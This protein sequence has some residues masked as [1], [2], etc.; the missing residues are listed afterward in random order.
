[1]VNRLSFL[2]K[3]H[4]GQGILCLLLFTLCAFCTGFGDHIVTLACFLWRDSASWCIL[5]MPL[6]CILPFCE[7][8]N[9]AQ[10]DIICYQNAWRLLFL[11]TLGS[12]T[13]LYTKRRIVVI[14]ARLQ[15]FEKEGSRSLL[16]PSFL[17]PKMNGQ[18]T[19]NTTMRTDKCCIKTQ[20]NQW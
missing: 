13:H 20:E 2:E 4:P 16:L 7:E 11:H 15:F 10:R 1:M 18:I 9:G 12:W 6:W 17:Y 19:Q 5:Y 8:Y 14:Y 3:I